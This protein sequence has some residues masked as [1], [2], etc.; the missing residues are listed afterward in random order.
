MDAHAGARPSPEILVRGLNEGI[1]ISLDLK[2]GR[3]YFTD[4][5]GSVY[6]SKLDGSDQRTL[7][8][9]LGALVGIEY[10][11]PIR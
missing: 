10:V 3:M 5:G 6:T 4:L 2:Q 9:H 8:T 7:L 11:E 1:G